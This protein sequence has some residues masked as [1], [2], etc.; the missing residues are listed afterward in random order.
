[1]VDAFLS[2]LTVFPIAKSRVLQIEF[3]SKDPALAA[4]GANTVAELFLEAQQQAKRDEAKAASAWLS[5]KIDELRGKVAEA[6][7]KVEAFRA[8]SGLLAGAN[9]H[10]GSEPAARRHDDA[11]RDRA[12]QPSERRRQGRSRF[13]QCCT[14]GGS[15]RF[16]R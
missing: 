15:T 11:A 14:M 10:D 7:S 5:V 12:L 1:M 9:G 13:A 3:S 8:S 2:R 4:R 16:R 6:D